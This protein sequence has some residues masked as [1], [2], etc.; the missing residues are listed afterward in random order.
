MPTQKPVQLKIRIHPEKKAALVALAEKQRTD[1]SKLI[2][3]DIDK[4]LAAEVEDLPA[5][6]D[7][8]SDADQEELGP[9]TGRIGFRAL[10]GDEQFVKHYAAARKMKPGL[11]MKLILRS[12]ISKNAP[13]PKDELA[14][15]AVT[16]NQ[17][18]A[19]GRNLNQLVKL[20]HTGDWPDSNAL[21]DL[22]KDTRL[23]TQQTSAEIDAVVKA[24]L[25]SWENDH[26]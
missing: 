22:L 11:V 7:L 10:P 24:N 3:A 25:L 15:L 13:M 21:V 19:I 23:L 9:L 12:W 20:A 1:L 4:R 8:T 6:P 17:L 5:P 18:A 16:S 2:M 26:A 14:A